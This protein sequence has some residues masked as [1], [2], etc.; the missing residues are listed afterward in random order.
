VTDAR[1]RAQA[2]VSFCDGAEE[3]GFRDYARRGRAVADDCLEAL[4][5]LDAERSARRAL[6]ERVEG[7]EEILL[8]R[9]SA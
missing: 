8:E 5:Q 9:G 2:F 1:T 6:Q 3:S 4:D 7:L